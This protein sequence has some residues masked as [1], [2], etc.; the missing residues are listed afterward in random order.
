MA[1]IHHIDPTQTQS[2][3]L[4]L[5]GVPT[6]V[7]AG[8]RGSCLGPEALRIAGLPR[9]LRELG[10]GV[11]DRGDIDGPRNP[12]EEPKSGGRH[13]AQV[14]A[15]CDALQAEVFA[16]LE[17]N[18]LPVIMGGDHSISMGS[19][20][21]AAQHCA[22]TGRPLYVLWLDAHTDFNTP[23]SS[24]SGNVHGMPVAALCG[25]IHSKEL[26]F[27]DGTP[28]VDPVNFFL[29]GI[30]SVDPIERAAVVKSGLNVYD[31]RAVDER[32]VVVIMREIL[33]KV[34][35][36][37]GHLHVSLDVDVLDPSIAPGV[38]TTVPG[39][40]TYRE[41][42]LCMEL[43][44]ESGLLGSLD[45]VELNPLLDIQGKSAHMLVDLAGSL[46]GKRIT[47]PVAETGAAGD[48]AASK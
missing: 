20:K 4:G 14:R 8:M 3:K 26:G 27:E 29:F 38:G 1:E 37:G 17:A 12:E 7:G 35:Q 33:D 25:R 46:F 45:I 42:H 5:I 41:A 40:A 10:H 34:A 30:R 31:M 2:V 19:V 47:N 9:A 44:H 28:V 18:E 39:G 22:E 15:W 32:S 36:T 43:I 23:V 24:P 6:D 21:G 48:R 16:A 13:V 11:V